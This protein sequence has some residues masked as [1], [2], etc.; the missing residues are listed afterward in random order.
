MG[1]DAPARLRT[2]LVAH[3]A[4]YPDPIRVR[5][6]DPVRLSGAAEIWDGHRWLWAAAADGREGW[7]PDDLV[8][9]AGGEAVAAAD[10]SALELSCVPGERLA[11][12]AE[13]HGWALCRNAAGGEGWVPARNLAPR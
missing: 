12:L 5:A 4:S 11:C 13:R 8:E 10:Y 9:T 1:A 3:E 2:V 7:M 6:G